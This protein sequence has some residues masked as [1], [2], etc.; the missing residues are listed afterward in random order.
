MSAER[1]TLRRRHAQALLNGL[2]PA[3]F[4]AVPGTLLE[5]ARHSPTG[6]RMLARVALRRASALFAPDQERW[7]TW[8]DSESWL[9]WSSSRLQSFTRLLGAIALGPALRMAVERQ[10][11]LF[12]REALGQE[13]W[14]Q[15]QLAAPWQGPAPDA[16]RQM[17]A[18][19]LRRCGRDAAMLGAAV[20]ERG[21]IEFLS[22][23]ER[24]D[25]DLAA[26][27]ALSYAQLPATPCSKESWLPAGTVA[28]LLT[29]E[30]ALDA[31]A[32]LATAAEELPP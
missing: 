31:A 27:L 13:H 16:V 32:P 9:G 20:H 8:Q 30:A 1:A 29:A 19:V 11:V 4:G 14:R 3:H 12:F 2:H 22:H 7:Q 28:D 15:A 18:A 24:R 26:R 5:S 21:Q 10:A 17:G 23:A 6:R 25:S